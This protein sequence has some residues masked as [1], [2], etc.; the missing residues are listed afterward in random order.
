M[1]AALRIRSLPDVYAKRLLFFTLN[2][3]LAV[4]CYSSITSADLLGLLANLIKTDRLLTTDAF[5]SQH[6]PHRSYFAE[7]PSCRNW[8]SFRSF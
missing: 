1:Y 7:G 6:A 8:V 2:P 5:N 4:L 3:F